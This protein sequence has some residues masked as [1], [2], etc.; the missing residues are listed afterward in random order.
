MESASSSQSRIHRAALRL[1]AERGNH[2]ISISE[3][4]QMAGVARGTIYNNLSSLD[5]LFEDVANELSLEMNRRVARS[6]QDLS[7]PA[8]RLARGMRL[9]IRRAH[10]EPEWGRFICRFALNSLALRQLWAGLPINDISQGIAD[11]I[12]HFDREQLASVFGL[13]A[14]AVLTAMM[15]VLEGHKTWRDAGQDSTE[16]VLRALGVAQKKARLIARMEL[17]ALP[18]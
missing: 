2:Q 10:D 12:Y 4:A 15:L 9:Y 18:E 6:F 5:T 14:G 17:P 11:G 3:L 7:S 16:M 13:I 8:E 1:F